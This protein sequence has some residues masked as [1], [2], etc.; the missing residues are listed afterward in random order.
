MVIGAP[1]ERPMEFALAL[2]DRV[3]IDAGDATAHQ[4]IGIEFPV[5]IAVGAVPIAAIISIFV[6]EADGDAV[7]AVRPEF[8]DQPVFKFTSP[9]ADKK[10][11]DRIT[12]L[13][14]FGAVPP[15]A[16]GRVSKRHKRRI[17]AVP[18]IF[19]KTNLLR[20]GLIV[21]WRKRRT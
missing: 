13:N 14:K 6:S 3:F 9:F 5:F 10:A 7:A 12:A 20:S 16:V 15:L 17:A 18:P 19:G 8:L 11:F 2:A 4:A 21:E 1:A